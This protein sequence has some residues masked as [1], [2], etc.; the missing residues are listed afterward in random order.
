MR[1]AAVALLVLLAAGTATPR[2]PLSGA[3]HRITDISSGRVVS[4]SREDLLRTPVLPGSIAKIATLV[5]ALES[6]VVQPSTRFAC[7]RRLDVDGHRLD[8]SHP[9]VGRPLGPAEALAHSCNSYFAAVARLLRREALD[10]AFSELGLPPSDPSSSLVSSALGIAGRRLPPEQWLGALVRFATSGTRVPAGVRAVVLDGLRWGAEFGT[11]SAFHEH[12]MSA[13]AK[14]GTAAMPGGGFE[15]LLIAVTPADHPSRAVVVMAPGAS[16]RDAARLAVERLAALATGQTQEGESDVRVGIALPEGRF[17][18]VTLPLEEYVSRVV[19]AEADPAS[20]PEA[21]QALAVVARTFAVK[22][23]ARHARE[24]FDLCDLTHCQVMGTARQA[25]AAAARA[26]GGQVLY[27]DGRVADVY[28]TASCGGHTE[29]PSA[30]WP[31]SADPPYLPSRTE[32]ECAGRDRWQSDL[33][34][35][36]LVRALVASGRRGNVVRDLAI[37]VLGASGRVAALRVDGLVPPEMTGGEF[38]TAVGRALG[39]QVLKSTLFRIE[40]TAAGYRFVGSGRGHG[41][42]LCVVGSSRM[43]AG[44]RSAREILERD[45]PG[46][47]IRSAAAGQARSSP[48]VVV[49]LPVPEQRERYS[50]RA[51][52]RGGAARICREAW[53]AGA[54]CRPDRRPPDGRVLHARDRPAVVDDR[55]HPRAPHRPDSACGAQAAR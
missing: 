2:Q 54:R 25:S 45:L 42:G 26:T 12:G 27:Y 47:E 29:R 3:A 21:R 17:R 30:V 9:D 39:W 43:A 23:R 22:N 35:G 52:G 10:R 28:Y 14:T 38:R 18:V 41:V 44:G 51:G 8:C 36:D 46:T 16:G 37:T 15:G 48:F 20:G 53:V 55:V 31:G 50:N 7:T 49:D 32:P 34:A 4:A 5:A 19:S 40:R 11:A 13:L 33:A 6:G 24:G 1:A